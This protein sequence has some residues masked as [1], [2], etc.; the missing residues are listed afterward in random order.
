MES[1]MA[2]S[3]DCETCSSR[4]KFSFPQMPHIGPPLRIAGFYNFTAPS[5]PYDH[6]ST[7]NHLEVDFL[8]Y[9]FLKSLAAKGFASDK[10]TILK[11]AAAP[12]VARNN[13]PYSEPCR[14]TQNLCTA[15]NLMIMDQL[16]IFTRL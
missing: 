14:F 13:K 2:F 4:S 7:A 8:I 15:L 1:A 6:F 5:T 12:S 3:S 11:R 16:L 9:C 10:T